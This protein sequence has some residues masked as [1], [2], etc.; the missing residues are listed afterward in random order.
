[1]RA[2]SFQL[3]VVGLTIP[4]RDDVSWQNE[5][6]VGDEIRIRVVEASEVDFP[7]KR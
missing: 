7:H 5:H 6:A 4:G 2:T 1:M 3:G